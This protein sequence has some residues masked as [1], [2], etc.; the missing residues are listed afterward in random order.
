LVQ[1]RQQ[2]IQQVQEIEQTVRTK[3]YGFLNPFD[4]TQAAKFINHMQLVKKRQEVLRQIEH[5]RA[6]KEMENKR[7][8]EARINRIKAE[9]KNKIANVIRVNREFINKQIISEK[10]SRARDLERYKFNNME[11]SSA[12]TSILSHKT[13]H[14]V[15]A[16]D[17]YHRPI[18]S[19]RKR[20]L[21]ITCVIVLTLLMMGYYKIAACFLVINAVAQ[22]KMVGE[23]LISDDYQ[24]N[25]VEQ[26]MVIHEEPAR[27]KANRGEV[28]VRFYTF[29]LNAKQE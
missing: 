12:S 25:I 13:E 23:G 28:T 29:N 7:K 17:V 3:N 11:V 1:L 9:V 4:E 22:Y 26:G 21:N 18:A 5:L 16:T 6:V 8:E 2:K 14:E 15:V 19:Y 24:I 20:P 10:E 27:K